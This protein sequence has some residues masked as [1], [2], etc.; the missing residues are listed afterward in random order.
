MVDLDEHS[1]VDDARLD[2]RW[3]RQRAIPEC[4]RECGVDDGQPEDDGLA[5]EADGGPTFDHKP[6][7]EHHDRAYAHAD[8]GDDERCQS[9]ARFIHFPSSEAP[10]LAPMVRH[11]STS[12]SPRPV[13]AALPQK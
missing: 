10:A 8:A 7:Q 5:P 11:A 1:V 3:D 9:L 12:P 4:E 6:Q 13:S 2:G